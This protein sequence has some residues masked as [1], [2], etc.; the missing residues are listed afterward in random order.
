MNK[1]N[2]IVYLLSINKCPNKN[3]C[4]IMEHLFTLYK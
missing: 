2:E 1:I 4:D 3:S